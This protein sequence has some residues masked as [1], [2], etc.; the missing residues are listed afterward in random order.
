MSLVIK[1]TLLVIEPVGRAIDCAPTPLAPGVY[2]V[3]SAADSA[4]VVPANGVSPQHCNLS[5]DENGVEIAQMTDADFKA[6]QDLAKETSYA[7][8]V[9]DNPDG[10][11]LLDMALEVE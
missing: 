5:V 6:W 10:Q 4:I 1:N 8:F 3:G 2:S 7:A 11:K 9:E